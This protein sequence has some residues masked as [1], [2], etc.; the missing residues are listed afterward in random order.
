MARF[1]LCWLDGT[2]EVVE[3]TDISDAFLK[4]DYSAEYVISINYY[5]EVD[6]EK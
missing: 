4:A 6:E 3:G 5:D 2:Q 1:V